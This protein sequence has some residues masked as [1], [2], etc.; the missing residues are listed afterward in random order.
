M[1]SRMFQQTVPGTQQVLLSAAVCSPMP[2]NRE[3]LLVVPSF[4]LSDGSGRE[5]APG[6]SRYRQRLSFM[7]AMVQLFVRLAPQFHRSTVEVCLPTLF[8]LTMKNESVQSALKRETK[9]SGAIGTRHVRQALCP[10]SVVCSTCHEARRYPRMQRGSRVLWATVCASVCHPRASSLPGNVTVVRSNES[11]PAF[12]RM[13]ANEPAALLRTRVS[14]RFGVMQRHLPLHASSKRL[15]SCSHQYVCSRCLRSGIRREC[16]VA[17]P[18][19]STTACPAH[20]RVL[21]V[22]ILMQQY[23]ILVRLRRTITHVRQQ[24]PAM[25]AN[26]GNPTWHTT[27]QVTFVC[28][29][30]VAQC[31]LS[32]RRRAGS[33]RTRES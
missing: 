9:V 13:R 14:L 25:D 2:C 22:H 17:I 26:E 3:A 10:A 20:P 19:S 31:A 32:V 16:S 18:R 11:V 1:R 30:R 4:T 7:S 21:P 24:I 5:S 27:K 6:L 28:K 12:K 33:G 29:R 15:R 23:L 8:I